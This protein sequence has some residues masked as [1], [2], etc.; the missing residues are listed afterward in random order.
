MRDA[1]WRGGKCGTGKRG[2]KRAAVDS[3]DNVL[4]QWLRCYVDAEKTT[5]MKCRK[6]QDKRV[7]QNAPVGGRRDS[8]K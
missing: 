1:G 8:N 6:Q 3:V 7:V 5:G 2:N 4:L